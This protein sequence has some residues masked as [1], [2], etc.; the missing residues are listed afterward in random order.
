MLA[1]ANT[2]NISLVTWCS[3]VSGSVYFEFK[4]RGL[5]GDQ[6]LPK[7]Q[8][9][10]EIISLSNFNRLPIPPPCCRRGVRR[11]NSMFQWD[12]VCLA[13]EHELEFGIRLLSFEPFPDVRT[14]VTAWVSQVRID[15]IS[16]D[17]SRLKTINNVMF[18]LLVQLEI[19][20]EW[21]FLLSDPKFDNLLRITPSPN[22]N[23]HQSFPNLNFENVSTATVNLDY[24]SV[25][26]CLDTRVVT[27][28]SAWNDSCNSLPPLG[29]LRDD[30]D[31]REISCVSC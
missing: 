10:G 29:S 15:I 23:S 11:L 18:V 4:S 2:W 17:F 26:Y 12:L 13:L 3:A 28:H 20:Y 30:S 14:F 24:V 31:V 19:K 7:S 9:Q 21:T 16:S 6:N 8:I 5:E 1:T 22:R 25:L 27:R